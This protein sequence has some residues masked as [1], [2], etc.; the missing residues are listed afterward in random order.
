MRGIKCPNRDCS[1]CE[2]INLFK[3]LC[4]F[5]TPHINLFNCSIQNREVVYTIRPKMNAWLKKKYYQSYII[6]RQRKRILIFFLSE[7]YMLAF[8]TK[9]I[10]SRVTMT[11]SSSH[12][13]LPTF[14]ASVESGWNR[15][16]KMIGRFW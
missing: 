4:A 6:Q 9:H 11:V 2:S 8:F 15:S 16:R 12:L 7:I 5:A 13:L 1:N 3:Y 10:F 14:P